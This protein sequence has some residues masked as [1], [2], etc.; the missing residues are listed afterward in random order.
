MEDMVAATLAIEVGG[1][2]M[3]AISSSAFVEEGL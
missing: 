3:R 2:R 1:T